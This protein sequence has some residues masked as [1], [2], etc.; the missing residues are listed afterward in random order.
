MEFDQII[1]K[2]ASD[3]SK[4]LKPSFIIGQPGDP[5]MKGPLTEQSRNNLHSSKNSGVSNSPSGGKHSGRSSSR[6]ENESKPTEAFI[7][8]KMSIRT[9]K[10]KEKS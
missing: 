9:K 1:N 3:P 4:S 6:Y 5:M 7:K 2:K 10:R 8:P